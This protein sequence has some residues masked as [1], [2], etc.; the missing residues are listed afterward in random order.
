MKGCVAYLL[1]TSA[2]AAP[3]ASPSA[4]A[5]AAFD[6]PKFLDGGNGP[7]AVAIGDLNRDGYGDLAVANDDKE[8]RVF[9]ARPGGGFDAPDVYQYWNEFSA[10]MHV[11]IGDMNRDRHQDVVVGFSRSGGAVSVLLNDGM[12]AF[13]EVSHYD[14]CFVSNTVLVDDFNGDSHRDVSAVSS[15]CF[16]ATIL[17]SQHSDALRKDGTWGDGYA[18]VGLSM[19][20]LDGDRDLDLVYCNAVSNVTVL[21]NDGRGRFP[22]SSFHDVLDQPKDSTV[23]DADADGDADI[24]TANKYTGDVKLLR[25]EGVMHSFASPVSFIS[26]SEPQSVEHGDLDRDGDIDLAVANAAGS[27]VTLLWNDGTGDFSNREQQP[28]GTRPWD[29]AI[30]DT[31]GDARLDVASA[32]RDDGMVGIYVN[33]LAVAP[34]EDGDGVPDE[35]DCAL[36]NPAAWAQ[37]RPLEDL[38][39]MPS[40]TAT[41]LSWSEPRASNARERVYDVLRSEDPRDLSDALCLHSDLGPGFAFDA[42]RPLAGEAFFYLVR[43]EN[44][45]GGA[46]SADASGEARAAPSCE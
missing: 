36:A 31:N 8:L 32:Y 19:G 12:G 40:G 26:G 43:R 9:F 35:E 3:L 33:R 34:D 5:Q 37:P 21:E 20:D 4:L 11:A 25:N 41:E 15:N 30:G 2:L 7:K 29:V 46:L 45:C 28:G 38:V 39:L 23:F 14:S 22:D 24:I 42:E 18:S 6:P 10:V 17:L 44:P 16:A 13:P 1:V 27:T